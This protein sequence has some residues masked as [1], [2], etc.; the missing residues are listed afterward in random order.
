MRTY[1]HLAYPFCQHTDAHLYPSGWGTIVVYILASSRELRSSQLLLVVLLKGAG[2]RLEEFGFVGGEGFDVCDG[3]RM[4]MSVPTDLEMNNL[5][6]NHVLEL[7]SFV[8][9]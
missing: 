5:T 4:S 7:E 6:S 1:K 2:G 8:S 3:T 9:F